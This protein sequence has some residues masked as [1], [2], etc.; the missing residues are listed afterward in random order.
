MYSEKPLNDRIKNIE[1]HLDKYLDNSDETDELENRLANESKENEE[2]K[3]KIRKLE[4]EK[5]KLEVLKDQL[6]KPDENYISLTTL[7]P[8]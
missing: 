2:L 3:T 1:E 6:E 8:L 4:E 7:I 5:A